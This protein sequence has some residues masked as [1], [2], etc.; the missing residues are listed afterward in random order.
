MDFDQER[1][2]DIPVLNRGAVYDAPRAM[3][4]SAYNPFREEYV[5]LL[6][7]SRCV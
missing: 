6:Y 5:C 2:V 7:T 4:N 1:T 3:S